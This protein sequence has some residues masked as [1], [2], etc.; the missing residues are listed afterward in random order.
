M[1][2][3]N[4]FL[5]LVIV[6]AVDVILAKKSYQDHKVVLIKIKNEI[7]LDAVKSLEFNSGVRIDS[8]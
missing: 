7:Q 8:K 6:C 2:F 5:I 4:I 1:N 3:L